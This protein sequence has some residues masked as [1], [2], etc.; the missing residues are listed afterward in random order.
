MLEVMARSA[1]DLLDIQPNS[2]ILFHCKLR[3]VITWH[4]DEEAHEVFDSV[5]ELDKS[6]F[7]GTRK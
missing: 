1:A 5:V 7:G 4:L 6:Y 3:E 2:A